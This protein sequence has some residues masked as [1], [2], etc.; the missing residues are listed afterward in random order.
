MMPLAFALI[1]CIAALIAYGVAGLIVWH[2]DE[3]LR[4]LDAEYRA[5]AMIANAKR[6]L[7]RG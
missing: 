5:F 4:R 7:R 6:E 1:L 3:K 2:H